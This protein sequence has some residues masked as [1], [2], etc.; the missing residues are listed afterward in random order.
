MLN[1]ATSFKFDED[2]MVSFAVQ[3]NLCMQLLHIFMTSY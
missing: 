3:F 2:R 1:Q